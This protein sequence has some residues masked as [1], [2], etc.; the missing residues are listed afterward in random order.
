MLAN[1]KMF[2][3]CAEVSSTQVID[4]EHSVSHVGKPQA[5]AFP[6]LHPILSDFHPV[7]R[8]LIDGTKNG[9]TTYRVLFGRQIICHLDMHD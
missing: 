7:T 8:C 9:I 1:L 3:V 4:P 5:S 2:E 6:Q